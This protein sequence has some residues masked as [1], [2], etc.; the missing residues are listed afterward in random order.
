MTTGFWFSVGFLAVGIAT[1]MAL[2]PD[3][4][5]DEQVVRA[6]GQPVR[7][8]IDTSADLDIVTIPGTVVDRPV[9][10]EV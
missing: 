10:T 6:D 8:A 1:A 5:R 3:R 7:P 4:I 9:A 2:L